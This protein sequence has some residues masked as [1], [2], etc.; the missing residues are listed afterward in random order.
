MSLK[1]LS[2][3]QTPSNE[4]TDETKSQLSLIHRS[5][6]IYASSGEK[7]YGE[8]DGLSLDIIHSANAVLNGMK[9]YH[10]DVDED[11]IC[12]ILLEHISTPA[13]QQ[14][15]TSAFDN[16]VSLHDK[17]LPAE[18]DTS[19]WDW[20]RPLFNLLYGDAFY[21]K[22]DPDYSITFAN[23]MLN[24]IIDELWYRLVSNAIRNLENI[25]KKTLSLI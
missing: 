17:E 1:R 4:S 18:F 14:L 5:V 16:L 24:F 23:T 25:K 3:T 13:I 19:Y 12:E 6:S 22:V 10:Y 7:G 21:S 2:L 9:G 20:E 15:L 8:D 11:G